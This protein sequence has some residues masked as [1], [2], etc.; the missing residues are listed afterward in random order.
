MFIWFPA[1]SDIDP[2]G[3]IPS[4]HLTDISISSPISGCKQH[5]TPRKPGIS[6]LHRVVYDMD[7]VK[8][9]KSFTKAQ[10]SFSDSN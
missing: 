4:R 10:R 1:N 5:K 2:V 3:G 9:K 8:K 6:C 7:E